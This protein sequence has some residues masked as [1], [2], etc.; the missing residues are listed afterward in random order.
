MAKLGGPITRRK[1]LAASA[2][3]ALG[4]LYTPAAALA[5]D[6]NHLYRWDIIKLSR[7]TDGKIVISPGGSASAAAEDGSKITV[8]GMGTFR[9]NSGQP[10]DVTGGGTWSTTGSAGSGSGTYDV[11][12]FVDFDVAPGFVPAATF[13]D[14]INGELANARAGLAVLQVAYSDGSDGILVVSCHL[15][16]GAPNSVFEGITASKGFTDY[17]NN[18]EQLGSP[19][20]VNA[21]RTEFHVLRQVSSP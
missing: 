2:I 14:N 10:Q 21:N 4:A 5:D 13:N 9:S 20:S 19:D 17:W 8:T 11:T 1:V 18:D 3:G 6:A 12:G 7:G 15:P 16:A